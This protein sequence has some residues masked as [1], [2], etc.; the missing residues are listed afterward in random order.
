MSL[1]TG[2]HLFIDLV[3]QD[4]NSRPFTKDLWQQ[5]A[6]RSNLDGTIANVDHANGGEHDAEMQRREQWVLLEIPL[7]ALQAVEADGR[8]QSGC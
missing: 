5:G 3:C 4:D 1:V 2:S 8:R 7:R 6:Q